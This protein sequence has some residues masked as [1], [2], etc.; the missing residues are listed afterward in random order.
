[1]LLFGYLFVF[2]QIMIDKETIDKI[3]NA[4]D[5]VDVVSDFV[6]LKKR[7]VNYIG[8]CPFHNEKTASFTVSPAKGIYKCFGCGKG[9]NSVNFI[10]EHEQ[11]S[12]VE[13]LKYLA[14][15]YHIEVVEQEVTDQEKEKNDARESM[16]VVNAFAQKTFT[17]NLTET[18]EGRAVGLKYF[19]ERGFSE[20]T[21]KK[22]ELGYCRAERD[23]FTKLAEQKGYASKFLV[24]TGLSIERENGTRFDR[25]SER[26]MF[27]IHNLM[28]KVIGFGGRTLRSDKKLAKYLNSPES[29]IYHKSKVLYGLYFAKKSITQNDKCYMVEGY[30]DVMSMHQAGIENVVA[31]SG[32][33]LTPDQI[34]L[35]KRFTPN[36]TVLYDGDAAGIKAALRG[37]DL[38][39][40]EGM[41]V[42]V[43]LL[44]DGDDPDSFAHKHSA[45]EFYDFINKNET[46]FI[47]FKTKLLLSDTQNDP[48]KKANLIQ[49]IVRT[50][51]VIPDGITRS[52]YIKECSGLMAVD[53]K[54][55]Y[56]EINK[57]INKNRDKNWSNFPPPEPTFEAEQITETVIPLSAKFEKYEHEI[58]RLLL[59]YGS[60]VLFTVDNEEIK[61]DIT[62]A[63]YICR[64]VEGE[65]DLQNPVYKLIFNEYTGMLTSK[66]NPDENFFIKHENQLVSKATADLLS[67]NH[68]ISKMWSKKGTYV[69][70]EEDNLKQV[71][72]NA[73]NGYKYEIIMNL[74][75]G[76]EEEIKKVQQLEDQQEKLETLYRKYMAYTQFKIEIAKTL[77]DRIIL[78]R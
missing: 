63:K 31:S 6:N 21:I 11:L 23:S 28:G 22:F 13:T 75:K 14:K 40:E 3:F 24:E 39:L 66:Q 34:R 8:N 37:I 1:M 30:T 32:T 76:V 26:V 12:Y 17:H 73:I 56:T 10:M 47:T 44:P 18:E 68:Q 5:I 62:T 45:T 33:A 65:I 60:R 67:T 51:A 69:N 74:L 70:T 7:G 35:I 42:K 61:E 36:I 16:L 50:I 77:G 57:I 72:D 78:K 41:N 58:L 15:R 49:D 43:V 54:I 29:P 4:A 19:K 38:V 55:L 48:V 20:I 2:Q 64:E 9:G 25:F 27:P 59:S 71:I 46:D 52:V 53:E